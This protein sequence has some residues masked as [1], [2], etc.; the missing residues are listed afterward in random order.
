MIQKPSASVVPGGTSGAASVPRLPLHMSSPRAAAPAAAQV[1]A[2]DSPGDVDDD[3]EEGVG[4][5]PRT[6][7][8][9]PLTPFG[10]TT[11]GD[12]DGGSST[13]E[14]DFVRGDAGGDDDGGGLVKWASPKGVSASHAYSFRAAVPEDDVIDA[15]VGLPA[16]TGRASSGEEAG[17]A[18]AAD[19]EGAV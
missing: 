1:A 6:G 19:A 9:W 18:A 3:D 8:G 17:A 5:Q 16:V 15:A 13:P 14:G 11:S 2:L 10:A 12:D 7:R 4:G